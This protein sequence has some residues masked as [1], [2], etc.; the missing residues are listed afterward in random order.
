MVR[1]PTLHYDVK[2]LAYVTFKGSIMPQNRQSLDRIVALVREVLPEMT[3]EE[4]LTLLA[5]LKHYVKQLGPTKPP[6][7]VLHRWH[8]G[9][10]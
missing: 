7:D 3:N 10:G 8:D 5:I 9:T 2:G 6:M 1:S 4:L